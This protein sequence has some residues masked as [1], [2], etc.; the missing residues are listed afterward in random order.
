MD[1]EII[2]GALPIEQSPENFAK[3]SSDDLQERR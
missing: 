1:C 3:P 2:D